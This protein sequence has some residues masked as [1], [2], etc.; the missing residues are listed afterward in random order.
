MAE[1]ATINTLRRAFALQRWLELNARSGT[2]YIESILANF[3]VQS[4][5]GRLNRPEYIGGSKQKMTISEVLSTAQTIDQASNDVPIGQMAGHGISVGGGNTFNYTAEEHGWIIGIINVQP[6]TAYSQGLPKKF[7][8]VLDRLDYYWP[9]FANI[10]E[11]AILNQEVYCDNGET[12][13]DLESTFG[14]IPRYAEYK[15]ENNR[16]SGEMRDTLNYWHM[17]REFVSAPVLN[18][19]FIWCDPTTRIFAD[20]SGAQIF[21]HIFNNITESA[22]CQNSEYLVYRCHVEIHLSQ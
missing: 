13:Q 6:K 7:S 8:R 17:G 20:E 1:A 5:D 10:G 16:V 12:I 4:S 19:S 14:Y 11:Q 22:R 3:G 2:R 18:D 9:S 15:Y 21:A